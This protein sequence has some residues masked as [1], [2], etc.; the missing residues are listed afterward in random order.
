MLAAS[1]SL[2]ATPVSR[3]YATSPFGTAITTG[4]QTGRQKETLSNNK[5]LILDN[6]YEALLLRIH[7]IRHATRSIDIQT[8]I[9]TNDECGRL[10][11]YELIQAA[12]R[13]VRVRIIADHF[14][15]D[16]DPK[17]TAF[18]ATVHPNI[19][20]KHYRPVA[21]RIRASKAHILAKTLFRFRNLNQRMHNKVMIF[22]NAMALTGG[23]NI[24]NTYYNYSLSMNFRDRD[25]LVI[26]PV[27]GDTV[28][29]FESFWNYK[30]A[31]PSG[32]LLDVRAIIDNGEVPEFPTKGDFRF[33]N[34]FAP[35]ER[36][37]D[38]SD[39]ITRT[40][41]KDLHSAE[42]VTF[43]S[44][45]PGKNRSLWLRGQ[46]RLTKQLV[47][48]V[49]KT[50]NTLVIQSPYFVLSKKAI[51]LFQDLRHKSPAVDITVSSNSF[52]STDNTV[53][54]SANYRL[55][56]TTI[57]DL[58]LSVYEFKPAPEDMLKIFPQYP[59]ML[60][61]AKANVDQG[62][63]DRLPF[64]CVHAKSFVRDDRIAYIGSYNLD[65]RS[66]NLNTEVGLLI[67]D[68]R[69]AGILKAGILRD[70]SHGNSWVIA[71]KQ[72]PLQLDRVNMLIQGISGLLPIDIW[73]IRN[74]SSFELT[75]GKTP[76]PPGHPDFYTHY[77]DVGSF[78]GAPPGL[79]TKEISTRIYKAIGGSATPLL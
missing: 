34:M 42:R 18:L 44:D 2:A 15:S 1:T 40:F 26:G 67:E 30:H 52:G 19:K 55:R 75:P 4:A 79:S 24:E 31:I 7:L 57:E 13:G 10:M 17:I 37:A 65:P 27:V 58:G 22:D 25:A 71:K 48:I 61:K 68:R 78:P 23:R 49:G 70:C 33:G 41:L 39:V 45:R 9:W 6:G 32:D 28:D 73:P 72:M 5:V 35:L 63:D 29:S 11:M 20:L 76:L 16:K 36:A 66:A 3:A 54:Y 14:V 64:L 43:M 62:S 21:N 53:A 38:D 12:K 8:F 59:G 77:R 74:T 51:E 56:S 50:E 69:I 47:K 46:G 60:A